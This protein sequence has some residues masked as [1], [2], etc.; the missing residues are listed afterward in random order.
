MFPGLRIGLAV[1]PNA[2]IDSFQR[3]KNTTD[4]DSS[5]ISQAALELYL[6][7]GMFKR[8]Q[9]VVSEAYT[10][11]ANIL[12]QSITKYLPDYQA[13]AEICM[14]SHIVLPRKINTNKL[15]QYLK[16][17]E[18]YIDTIDRNYLNGFYRERILKLN[19]SNVEDYKIEK[20][21]QKIAHALKHPQ[22]HF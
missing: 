5:M 21:I 22:N 16:L 15:I 6:K 11:R 8:Y 14:H 20:G 3:H 1:L 13:S 10:Q 9:K 18:I 17:E 2:L 12:Q 7:S 19:V 4:I